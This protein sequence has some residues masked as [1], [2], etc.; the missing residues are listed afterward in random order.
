MAEGT[1][2]ESGHPQ[3]LASR[4]E[5]RFARMLAEERVARQMWSESRTW[6]HLR[7]DGG[8]IAWEAPRSGTNG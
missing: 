4:P 1:I 3:A 8:E 6:R 2:V 5:S 7:L